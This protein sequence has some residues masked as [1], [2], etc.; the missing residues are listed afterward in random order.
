MIWHLRLSKNPRGGLPKTAKATVQERRR[1][2]GCGAN[3][4]HNEKPDYV[5]ETDK[6]RFSICH[7]NGG[8]PVLL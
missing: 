2:N 4:K 7:L 6:D 3:Q 1:R 5:L 8:F